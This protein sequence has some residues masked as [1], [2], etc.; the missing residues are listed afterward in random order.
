MPYKN[1]RR[2]QEWERRNRARRLARRQE[3]R[4]LHASQQVPEVAPVAGDPSALGDFP[5]P[6]LAGGGFLALFNPTV[7][8]GA[9]IL[10]LIA[11]AL[12]KKRWQWWVIGAAIVA[13]ALFL[14]SGEQRKDATD[15]IP[16]KK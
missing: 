15:T 8:L 3:L 9:G 11:A 10:T 4:R 6:L 13:L 2:K 5:W 16:P 1:S 7:A 12:L 14:L